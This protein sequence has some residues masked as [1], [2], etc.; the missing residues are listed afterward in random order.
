MALPSRAGASCLP[1]DCRRRSRPEHRAALGRLPGSLQPRMRSCAA[2]QIGPDPDDWC[3]AI[4]LARPLPARIRMRSRVMRALRADRGTRRR[5]ATDHVFGDTQDASPVR[6]E[7]C[8][9]RT[10]AGEPRPAST[11]RG[12]R[13]C[14]HGCLSSSGA[15]REALH[16]IGSKRGTQRRLIRVERGE[17]RRG[18]LRGIA[19]LAFEVEATKRVQPDPAFGWAEGATRLASAD[20]RSRRHATLGKWPASSFWSVGAGSTDG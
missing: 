1:L 8:F 2:A 16:S 6:F 18:G 10:A 14:R 9:V 5:D 19:V 4:A 3:V 11:G 7:S 17:D 13:V 12:S 20:L 15:W